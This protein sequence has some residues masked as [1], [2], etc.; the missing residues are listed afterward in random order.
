MDDDDDPHQQR[1]PGRRQHCR[2]LW[3]PVAKRVRRSPPTS[4]WP[5]LRA[6]TPWLTIGLHGETGETRQGWRTAGCSKQQ[7][8]QQQQCMVSVAPQVWSCA[9]PGAANQ[10]S[11]SGADPRGVRLG[12][13]GRVAI[14]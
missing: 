9:S 5:V 3:T 10:G 12:P 13:T 2:S 11:G 4:C 14:L 7:Q 6:S 1:A 8:Q